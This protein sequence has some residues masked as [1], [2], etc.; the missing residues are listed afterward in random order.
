MK[1]VSPT[2]TACLVA[3]SFLAMAA[4]GDSEP[5][6]PQGDGLTIA[7]APLRL[8]GVSDVCYDL[9]VTNGPD[10]TG[11]TVWSRGTPGLNG[12]TPDSRAI[13][14]TDFGNG[15]GGDVTYIGPCDAD[16][17][18]GVSGTSARMN[19]VTLWVDGL[20]D[21]S[22]AYIDPTGPEGWRNP[23][24][25]PSGC[26]LD[27]LC[28]ENVDAQVEF[29]LTIMRQAN[30][31]FFDIAVNFDD[32][33]CSAKVDCAYPATATSPARPIELVFDPATG[34]RVQTVVWAFACTD[35]DPGATTA[36]ATHLYMDDLVLDCGSTSYTVPASAGPGNIYPDA[37]TPPAPLVQAMEFEGVE[38]IKNG[39]VDADKRYWSVALGLKASFFA[40]APNCTLRTK[41]TASNGPLSGGVTPPNTNYPVIDVSVQINEG[42]EIIC[43]QHGLNGTEAH[44]GVSTH[45]TGPK[46]DNS[47]FATA[48]FR[49][50]GAP[51]AGSIVT[52]PISRCDS[53]LH[54]VDH[55]GAC[56][57]DVAGGW[58]S[59][60]LGGCI[61]Y[62]YIPAGTFMMG[63][64]A[65]DGGPYVGG[66]NW[67]ENQHRVTLTS[68]FWMS[69]SEV[70][71][72]QWLAMFP[73]SN[74]STYTADNGFF[75]SEESPDVA[76][77]NLNLPVERVSWF[78]AVAYMNAL[79]AAQVPP[80]TACY[81]LTP[82]TGKVADGSL[83]CGDVTTIP[84]CTGYR[85]PTE[86]EWEYAARAG[87]ST[88]TYATGTQLLED[89]AWYQVNS[90]DVSV[91]SLVPHPVATKG[92]NSANAFGLYDMLGNVFEWVGDWRESYDLTRVPRPLYDPAGPITGDARVY[93]GGAFNRPTQHLRAA[94]RS[95]ANP[96]T[97][98]VD[99][100]FRPVRSG[101]SLCIATPMDEVCDGL[102]N[103]CNGVVDDAGGSC[104]TTLY[105]VCSQGTYTCSSE[106]LVCTPATPS[107]EACDGLDNDCD[108]VVDNGGP[109]TCDGLDNDCDGVVD[110][111]NPLGGPAETCDG[112]DN[113]CDG[114][115][116]NVSGACSPLVGVGACSQGTYACS[117]GELVCDA[118]TPS[119][120]TCDNLDND[121]NGVVDNGFVRDGLGG[122]V[123][124]VYEPVGWGNLNF[125]PE[126]YAFVAVAAGGNHTV[127]LN[128]D[129]KVVAWGYGGVGQTSVP[130]GLANVV[131]IAAGANHTVALKSDGMVVAWGYNYNGQTDVPSG[132]ANVVAIA[133]RGSFTVAL[134]GDG[135]VVAW[136]DNGDGQINVPTGLANVIVIAIAVG[137]WHS[138]A[139][140]SDGTVVAWGRNTYGQTDVPSGLT[141]VV[142]ISATDDT[143]F[144]LKSDGT[145]VAWGG[146]AYSQ[147]ADV[148]T[149]LAAVAGGF[150]HG[151][152]VKIDGTVVAWGLNSDGQ[153]NV[154]SGLANV[155]A[156]SG[157]SRHSAA[158]TADGTIVT[159]GSNDSGQL[160]VP[161]PGFGSVI[162]VAAG[163]EHVLALKSDGTVVGWRTSNT[164]AQGESYSDNTV[165]LPGALSN[166]VAIA[167]GW[168]HSAILKADRTVAMVGSKSWANQ[169]FADELNI[170]NAVAIAAGAQ[171]TVALRSD[172]TVVVW[173]DSD[174]GQTSVP[175][176][177]D[178]VVA[179]AAGFFHTV[180]LQDDGT[181]VAWGA[182]A[183]GQTTVPI[184]L[185]NVVAIA[186]GRDHTVALKRNGT[187]VAWGSNTYGQSTVPSGLTDV[188][189][190]AA[191]EY[192]TTAL[193]SDGTVVAW[194]S[195]SH[196]QSTVPGGVDNIAAI[197]AGGRESLALRRLGPAPTITVLSALSGLAGA[198]LTVTGT[199]FERVIAVRVAGRSVLWTRD[200]ATQLRLTLPHANV[201]GPVEVVTMSGANSSSGVV[202]VDL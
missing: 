133:A 95:Q 139:L 88:P 138:V 182:N 127:A 70:T 43:S 1:P 62:A 156:V 85:L 161:T 33:F 64:P 99:I 148:P 171:H 55:G 21:D 26:T 175:A 134:K 121:C 192:H 189:A 97:Q 67:G 60:G 172:G 39:G 24:D 202:D 35:G 160:D 6:A 83:D 16:G 42:S 107:A 105:G 190:I 146:D 200:S 75:T 195:D 162:A 27:V 91:G 79:S 2:F 30:Q 135:T 180:A 164:P 23:C 177:L 74:P 116:D 44:A 163:K 110:N 4:C 122:C 120:E 82:C 173:S 51:T 90:W 20:Y 183:S 130:S 101:V 8:P 13:C 34:K 155:V 147:K 54:L 77:G 184:D 46:P 181:V 45:Y 159:W 109:E 112:L 131:A 149:G 63:A 65:G 119:I 125:R 48:T 123:P 143:T 194:G 168:R 49:N 145:V 89:L 103:D 66:P 188:V 150:F 94:F 28:E 117:G 78:M 72:R 166:V 187:V 40:T 10:G 81:N 98:R 170:N 53:M 29:N 118:A 197:A 68:S 196:G 152:G 38:L 193:K 157:G 151:V 71:Q 59:D 144:A 158:L 58:Q 87:T 100:G 169:S 41:A 129:G 9:R 154:P 126:P 17:T 25:T 31:G 104:E 11:D 165:P 3:T 176:G 106:G 179:I 191:G 108:G 47:G 18:L 19:S 198:S 61:E 5:K 115:V 111:G 37:G 132:L 57:C 102:D 50:E 124:I 136:G 113:N 76:V 185:D 32:I 174:D 12:G 84:G 137:S 92:L 56:V 7:V 73:D 96:F 86:A 140:K 80:L 141:D 93:R 167:A 153:T 142:A 52:R 201:T 114:V 178:N 186:A 14:S 36:T 22:G 69:K 199:N 15:V 128:G